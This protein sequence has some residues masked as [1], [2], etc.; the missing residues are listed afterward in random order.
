MRPHQAAPCGTLILDFQQADEGGN[1]FFVL[2]KPP[3]LW[4][5]V[6][7]ASAS[8]EVR[9]HQAAPC[10]TLILDFQQA[11]E[12]GNEF[13]VLDKPPRLW[14]FVIAAPAKTADIFSKV[15]LR[16]F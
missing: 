2:D 11:D 3:R 15:F 7:A 16:L 13:F 9:P 14:D 5:F 6:I 12:G 8:Q 4:D 10:G 1:E